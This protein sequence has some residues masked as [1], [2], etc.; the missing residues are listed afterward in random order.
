MHW[1]YS[2]YHIGCIC[3]K[4]FLCNLYKQGFTDCAH[5]G[6]SQAFFTV[7][8][9]SHNPTWETYPTQPGVVAGSGN[10]LARMWSS[11]TTSLT[12]HTFMPPKVRQHALQITKLH[13]TLV[14]KHY[15][16]HYFDYYAVTSDGSIDATTGFRSSRYRWYCSWIWPLICLTVGWFELKVL[17]HCLYFFFLQDTQTTLDIEAT[18][19]R[20]QQS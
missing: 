16:N 17:I 1:F 15:C 3:Q 12:L 2:N 19:G 6:R 14:S 13:P 8:F 7:M 18:P 20:A 11:A 5:Q 9:P 4:I 10:V